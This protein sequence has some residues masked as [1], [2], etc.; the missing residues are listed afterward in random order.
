MPSYIL[1]PLP[2][3]NGSPTFLRRDVLSI[4]DLGYLSRYS[5]KPSTQYRPFLSL[6]DVSCPLTIPYSYDGVNFGY[7]EEDEDGYGEIMQKDC[8]MVISGFFERRDLVRQQL[9]S[10]DEF[11]QNTMQELV[12][13][14]S[15]LIMDQTHLSGRCEIKFGQTYLPSQSGCTG[16]PARDLVEE[17]DVLR[18]AVHRDEKEGVEVGMRKAVRWSV[19]LPIM[20]TYSQNHSPPLINSLVEVRSAVEKGGKIISQFQVKMFR[21]NQERFLGNVIKATIPYIKVDNSIWGRLPRMEKSGHLL[22]ILR[23]ALLA[24]R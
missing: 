9:D 24:L 20:Y 15:D 19:W 10:F 8:W 5:S 14:N 18:A 3:L 21:Q 12:D 4:D 2:T 16:F 17:P 22:L 13:E 7:D 1:L 11:V 6:Y 23:Q